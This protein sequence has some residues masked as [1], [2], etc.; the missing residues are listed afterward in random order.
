M[1]EIEKS[2]CCGCSACVQACPQQCISFIED[3][4]G[5]L[6]PKIEKSLCIKCEL[7]KK[8]CPF[9]VTTPLRTF[10]PET[11]GMKSRDKKILENSSSGGVFSLLSKKIIEEGGVVYGAAMTDDMKGTHHIRVSS[12]KE[13]PLLRGSK[14]LQSE[15]KGCFKQVKE[16]LKSGNKVLFSGVPCQIDGLKLYLNKS[17]KNLI[18]VEVICHGVPSPLL[19]RKYVENLETRLGAKISSVNFRK[20]KH[21]WNEYGLLVNGENISQFQ[22]LNQ[23]SY[24]QMFL[25]NYCLRPSCYTCNAKK[26]E[27]MADITIADFWGVQNIAPELYDSM[28]ISL[29]F[30]QSC[31][32]RELFEKMKDLTVF[33]SVDFDRA[34]QSNPAYHKSAL[35]PKTRNVFFK[36]LHTYGYKYVAKK[37]GHL[38]KK[39][40]IIRLLN[41]TP[42]LK[43]YRK[44]FRESAGA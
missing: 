38:T 1:I 29:V 22:S 25:K 16:D 42:A 7:C 33:K 4:E 15:M 36:E 31:K 23:N 9:Q 24:L 28:G 44:L 21:S 34:I 6:Y 5:F 3:E 40:K 35:K 12:A 37:Y 2:L 19:W 26:I 30:I 32:G 17:Y 41:R 11:Y 27:S 20:K 14:Y 8:V 39:E 13:L 43:V 18:C 10:V